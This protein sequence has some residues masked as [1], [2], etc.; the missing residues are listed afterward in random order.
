VRRSLN[1]ARPPPSQRPSQHR[2]L[3]CQHVHAHAARWGHPRPRARARTPA[4][5][6]LKP[7]LV[8]H[9]CVPSHSAPMQPLGPRRQRRPGLHSPHQ[10]THQPST[11]RAVTSERRQAVARVRW[12]GRCRMLPY[13]A[14]AAAVADAVACGER[15][16]PWRARPSSHVSPSGA[17]SGVPVMRLRMNLY[18]A[19]AGVRAPRARADAATPPL[20]RLTDKDQHAA[21]G[22][23]KALTLQAFGE[24]VALLEGLADDASS[25]LHLTTASTSNRALRVHSAGRIVK[26]PGFIIWAD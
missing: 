25:R 7:S 23:A 22:A 14:K 16:L 6:G 15:L 3:A 21:H 20:H 2:Q 17:A 26:S 13:A 5:T 4:R 1:A 8:R 11:W 19:H 10:C 12:V 9:M 18:A 24:H